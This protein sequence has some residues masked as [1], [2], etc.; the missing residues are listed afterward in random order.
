VAIIIRPGRW[1]IQPSPGSQINFGHP[2]V[3]GLTFYVLF[4]AGG[5]LQHAL[6]PFNL[7]GVAE[8][9]VVAP[10]WNVG[11]GGYS[12]NFAAGS[13]LTDFYERG[14]WN[15]PPNV[16]TAFGRFR[17]TANS[18][19]TAVTVR[20][21]WK[22]TAGGAPFLSWDLINTNVGNAGQDMVQTQIATGGGASLTTGNTISLP[23]G[24]TAKEFTGG[25]TY[26]NA[27]LKLWVNGINQDSVAATGAI[28]YDQTA[29][30]R[31]I[32]CGISSVSYAAGFLGQVYWVG[33]WNRVMDSGEIEALHREPYSFFTPRVYRKFFTF[34]Q[35]V[36]TDK[37][38]NI[39]TYVQGLP[40]PSHNIDAFVFGGQG[41]TTK[42]HSIDAVIQAFGLLPAVKLAGNIIFPIAPN[43]FVRIL[44][45][46]AQPGRQFVN[47]AATINVIQRQFVNLAA[48]IQITRRQFVK[49]AAN[50]SS[51]K[52]K[53]HNID[54]VVSTPALGFVQL[55]AT[56]TAP[57]QIGACRSFP[58][59]SY[60]KLSAWIVQQNDSIH[61]PNSGYAPVDDFLS[62][63]IALASYKP[64]SLFQLAGIN[65]IVTAYTPG[66]VSWQTRT[67]SWLRRIDEAPNGILQTQIVNTHTLPNGAVITTTTTTVQNQDVVT[68]T[69]R[70]QNSTTPNRTSVIITEKNKFGQTTTRE[71]DTLNINGII[72]TVEK[73]TVFSQPPTTENIQP[74]RVT[75]LDGVQH[76]QFFSQIN[77]EWAGGDAEGLT[78]TTTNEQ[79]VPGI[80]NGNTV[81]QFGN[82]IKTKITDSTVQTPD[83]K[84]IE[85]HTEPTGTQTAG[86]T[87][88]DTSEQ[89]NGLQTTTHTVTTYPNGSQT[90]SDKTVTN[91]PSDSVEVDVETVTDEYGQVTIT[92]TNTETKTFVDPTTGNL[93]TT[94]TKTVVVNKSGVITTDTQTTTTN[95]FED[96]IVN[97]K[98]QVYLIQ[99]FTMN[100]V[101]DEMNMYALWEINETHQ[102]NFALLELFGQQL[103]NANLTYKLR[104][105]LIKQFNQANA[106]VIP[107]TLQANGK[108]F[109]VVFAPSASAFRPKYIPGTEPHVYELQL[110]LQSR[111]NLITG[112]K[113]F[114]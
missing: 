90:V 57:L 74:I 48:T 29:T 105:N 83:G 108:L 21:A 78:Q 26:D 69:T 107:V 58:D 106:C 89:F 12:R 16:I 73:K 24:T 103:G 2:L 43:A 45:T 31:L 109:Q 15:E 19:N 63:Q 32:I 56:I 81:D 27:H 34:N 110:I 39:D 86:T 10:T 93:R 66:V 8:T 35:G 62:S 97:D 20:K 113:G 44:G 88:I 91:T 99:E 84:T 60:V 101:I 40:S 55:N 82:P 51:D 100:V 71:L 64:I 112:T 46:V 104:Q 102:K 85:T 77:N 41:G 33:V 54:A 61:L 9:A 6:L 7:P 53:V 65:L 52:L 92:T 70:I 67:R 14:L 72:S 1:N 37:T 75:T 13:G 95:D 59:A 23:A 111:S 47:L 5:G 36:T 22:N 114:F 87:T 42:T 28:T 17:R 80:L 76:Y 18:P 50:I 25:L 3:N 4:N 38:H 30:G 94:I 79:I 96:D 11:P 98:I 49:L 68:V